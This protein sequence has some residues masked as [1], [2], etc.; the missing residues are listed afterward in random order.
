MLP[1][2]HRRRRR[3]SR[4][5]GEERLLRRRLSASQPADEG[6]MLI[7][8]V[9]TAFLV[10]LIVVAVFS[11]FSV[12]SNTSADQRRHDQAAVLA[13]QSQEQ[14]RTD[15]ANALEVLE[16]T[17]H[18]YTQTLGGT[19]YTISESSKFINDKT[20]ASACTAPGEVSKQNGSYLQVTSVV[21]WKAVNST[22]PKVE[23]SSIITPPTGSAL[24]IDVVNGAS[25][26]E[27]VSGVNASVEY[28]G[29]ESTLPTLVEGTT[30]AN[31]CVVFG[32]IPATTAL[33]NVKPPLG[34]VTP[35]DTF[36]IPS[37]PVTLAPNLTTHKEYV[38]NRGGAIKA[39]FTYNGSPVK[40]E[41]F[42][43]SNGKLTA[44]SFV[45]GSTSYK[46]ESGGEERYTP[47][48]NTQALTAE[49]PIATNYPTGNLFPWAAEKYLVFAG[50]CLKNN[51]KET[52]NPEGLKPEEVLVEPGKTATVKIPMSLVTLNVY[53]GTVGSITPTAEELAV[54]ITNTGCKTPTPNDATAS[55][56]IHEQ[57]FSS[58]HLQDP[59]QP[60]GSSFSLC[61]YS[62]TTKNNYT[63]TY[64]TEKPA[65]ATRNIYLG[66]GN[67]GEQT[68]EPNT[69][70]PC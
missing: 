3:R 19:E 11:G 21:T 57:K 23:Q 4:A 55:V 63:V 33:V 27:G 48:A 15:P 31:G 62:K 50:D 54:R 25:P 2:D 13:A 16:A 58:G 65:G 53:T 8:V 9:I 61:V 43:A 47:L 41:T 52:S 69:S 59:Y 36:K 20:Q 42:V 66:S 30:T 44:P 70:S 6:F 40:G 46:Y 5:P 45:L 56:Y 51:V 67:A 26:E 29:V 60:F 17:P 35:S 18:S 32:A 14:L 24:E 64:A 28:T 7:E 49:T 1:A 68:Y 22:Y 34:Y 38:V 12:A 10:G 37:E 39:E